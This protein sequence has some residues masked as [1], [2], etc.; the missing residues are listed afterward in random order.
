MSFE[1][2]AGQTAVGQLLSGEGFIAPRRPVSNTPFLDAL[3]LALDVSFHTILFERALS[4]PAL[5]ARSYRSLLAPSNPIAAL[6]NLPYQPLTFQSAH[7]DSGSRF[8]QAFLDGI[9]LS[10]KEWTSSL[11]PWSA[12]VEAGIK[13]WGT[14]PA[15]FDVALTAA[16]ISAKDER[17]RFGSDFRRA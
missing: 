15:L 16:G 2:G 9:D 17:G 3:R 8:L 7:Y 11:K 1:P 14:V 6:Q 12:I 10:C 4:D 5:K 13:E